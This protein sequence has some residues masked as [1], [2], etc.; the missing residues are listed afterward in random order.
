MYDVTPNGVC[1]ALAYTSNGGKALYIE[2]MKINQTKRKNKASII[3]E[4]N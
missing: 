4:S 2:T 1:I 3:N